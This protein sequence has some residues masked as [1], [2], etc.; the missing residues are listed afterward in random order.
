MRAL[1]YVG[2]SGWTGSARACVMA[3]RGLAER[4][5]EPFIACCADSAVERH[6]IEAEIEIVRIDP[7]SWFGT[8]AWG[9]RRVLH[10]LSIDVIFVHGDRDQLVVSTA[11]RLAERGA[12]VRRV[13]AFSPVG[14]MRSGRLSLRTTPA[15]LIF[16]S[17]EE[18]R[19]AS[20]EAPG[21]PS[22]IA[23]LG[24]DAVASDAI[25]PATRASLGAP[26]RALLA[27]CVY[28]PSARLRLLATLRTL[29]VLSPRHRALYLV[30][31][32]RGSQEDD[33]RLHAAA[34][35]VNQRTSFLGDRDDALAV[36]RA[37][38]VGWVT[39]T[40]DDGALALLDF[41]SM[42]IP[43]LAERTPLTEHYVA[44]Q[45][46]GVLIAPGDPSQTASSVASFFANGERREAMGNAGRARVQREFPPGAMIDGFERAV[47]AASSRERSAVR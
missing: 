27:V 15:G 12:V 3:A 46:G 35:G 38:D 39:A 8:D 19:A 16:N 41:M 21:I 44:D 28:D 42:R 20:V 5:H 40:G 25:R 37:A 9:L 14:S 11:V 6:A 33:L 10:E 7:P 1:F 23:P 32:G 18:R 22:V 29:A 31:V 4:D 26:E 34:L 36:M 24:I 2:E 30:V 13:P 43:V 47:R 45:I 17:E